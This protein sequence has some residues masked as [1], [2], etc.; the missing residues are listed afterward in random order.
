[1][2]K[3][4]VQGV[5][6]HLNGGGTEMFLL[7]ENDVEMVLESTISFGLTPYRIDA[8]VNWFQSIGSKQRKA[9]SVAH[10]NALS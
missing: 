2:N 3:W 10:A 1:M 6:P 7:Q 9:K 8:L 5:Y 4:Y